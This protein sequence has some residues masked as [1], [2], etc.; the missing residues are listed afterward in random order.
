[1][2]TKQEIL[3]LLEE[4]DIEFIRLQFTDPLGILRNTAVTRRSLKKV[5]NDDRYAFN[6]KKVF[7]SDEE[8]LF[9]KPD[10]STFSI[11]PWRPQN[12]KV[13]RFICDVVYEDGTEYSL[14]P[15]TIL[16][17][18][19][20]SAEEKGYKFFFNTDCEFFLFHNDENGVPTTD[21]SEAAGYMDVAPLDLGE[22]ARRDMILM[23]EDMGFNIIA[24]HHETSPAQHE[25]DF[26][27]EESMNIADAMITFKN[28]IRS[29]AMR[30]GLYA[31]FMPKP[32]NDFA[33][34][35]M[36]V[37]LHVFKDDKPVFNDLAEGKL[38]SEGGAFAAGI[39]KYAPE[40]C[41]ITNPIV[42]SYKRNFSDRLKLHTRKNADA[43][44]EL[45]FPDATSNPYLD[46]ALFIAAGMKGVEEKLTADKNM[47]TAPLPRNLYDALIAAEKGNLAKEVLGDDFVFKY[48]KARNIEW[49]D[50]MSYVG[51]WE[52]KNYLYRI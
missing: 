28:S 7:N 5:L 17:K 39:M 21:T 20:R 3:D 26:E 18:T 51:E 47:V 24:S 43:K 15:R 49:N 8:E 9:L 14:S 34:S 48:L 32:R 16:K 22:N 42:N 44:L 27:E 46:V 50:Y 23:L 45:L 13:A 37:K 1:M 33:G 12:R 19:V 2:A 40:M 31:T 25:I 29:I 52:I 30:F 35:G 11:L 10:L 41:F 38:D 4:E 6:A 36:H